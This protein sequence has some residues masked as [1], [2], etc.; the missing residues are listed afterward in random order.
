MTRWKIWS[1]SGGRR[2]GEP[3]YYEEGVDLVRHG[4][5]HEALIS[6]RLSLKHQPRHAATLEQMAVVYTH[7]GLADEAVRAYAAALEERPAAPPPITG[8]HSFF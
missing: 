1:R 5:Y 4:H 6:F 3:D 8:W 7:I 2:A